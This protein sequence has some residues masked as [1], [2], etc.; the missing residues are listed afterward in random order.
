M[1]KYTL[2]IRLVSAGLMIITGTIIYIIARS[3]DII[4]FNW[5]PTSIIEVFRDCSIDVN[6]LAG[7]FIVYCLPDG[8]WYG[9][10]LLLQSALLD[11]SIIS[12]SI[13]RISII[14]PFVWEILQIRKDVPGTFDP[15]DLMAYFFIIILFIT[16]SNNHH[17]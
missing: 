12:K 13:Y 14:L 15:M 6:S 16:F 9:A 3:R 2:F 17:E 5:I 11:K 4:F 10:L 7:Y 1:L 8:L